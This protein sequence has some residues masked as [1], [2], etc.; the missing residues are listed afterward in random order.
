[1]SSSHT[2]AVVAKM[3]CIESKQDMYATTIRLQPVYAEDGP[4][5]SWSKA[6]PSGEVT[7]QITNP[8]AATFFRVGK[9]YLV[10]FA[11]TED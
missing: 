7:M 9:S 2:S 1:M 8:P 10:N 3:R 5:K 6:T 11:E 4:N